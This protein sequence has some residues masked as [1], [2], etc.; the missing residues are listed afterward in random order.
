MVQTLVSLAAKD[1]LKLGT[2]YGEGCPGSEE[3]GLPCVAVSPED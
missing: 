3:E 2:C 1:A